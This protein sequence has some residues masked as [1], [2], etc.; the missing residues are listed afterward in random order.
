MANTKLDNLFTP[1]GRLVMGSLTEKATTDQ[2]NKPIPPEKQAYFFGVAVPKSAP[3]ANELIGRLWQMAAT[4]YAQAPLV[5]A[6]INMGLAAKDFSWKIQDGDLPVYDKATGAAKAMPDYLKGC[7]IFKFKTQFEISACDNAGID[8]ARK[9]IKKGDY[10]DVMFSTQING[11]F[12][13]TAGIY[14]NPNAIRRLGFGEAIASGVV[15]SQA[16][17]GQAASLPP[18]ATVMPTAAGALPGAGMLPGAPPAGGM[19]GVQPPVVGYPLAGTPTGFAPAPTAP[20]A[21]SG[22]PG[23]P[24]VLPPT[25]SPSSPGAPPYPAILTPPAPVVPPPP[26]GP[27]RPLD[28]THIHAA[29]TPGEMWWINGAWQPAIR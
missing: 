18:G 17:K 23:M 21:A 13:D 22:M 14:L 24:G 19:P 6:Q 8:I 29:G 4:D 20:V 16:F 7:W 27:Q 10:V 3:G 2:D 12:D 5:M 1:G 11:K 15:A 26:A 28:P 9:D 25:A